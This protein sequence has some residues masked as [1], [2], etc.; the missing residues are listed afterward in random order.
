MIGSDEVLKAAD[1]EP[2]FTPILV[3]GLKKILPLPVHRELKQ[4]DFVYKK[5]SEL[6]N[7][8]RDIKFS[9]DALTHLKKIRGSGG[10]TEDDYNEI[11]NSLLKF[12]NASTDQQKS[13]AKE[14]KD[15]VD[16]STNGKGW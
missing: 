15:A 16:S 10:L 3:A 9:D 5:W 7:A 1:R 11:R 8:N 4:E 12:K 13:I 14:I 2:L 6:N